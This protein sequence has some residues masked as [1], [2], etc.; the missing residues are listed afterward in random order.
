MA[1]RSDHVRFSRI[2]EVVAAMLAARWTWLPG[3]SQPRDAP[4]GTQAGVAALFLAKHIAV[5]DAVFQIVR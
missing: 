2:A 1:A 5:K 4:S 3:Q